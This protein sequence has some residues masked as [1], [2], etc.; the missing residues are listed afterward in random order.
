[1]QNYMTVQ[2]VGANT[3][4]DYAIVQEALRFFT[5]GEFKA[6]KDSISTDDKLNARFN[7]LVTA[8]KYKIGT[9]AAAV[10][11]ADLIKLHGFETNLHGAIDVVEKALQ[12]AAKAVGAARIEEIELYQKFPNQTARV[13]R[14]VAPLWRK[15]EQE[16]VTVEKQLV[17]MNELERDISF[18]ISK[19]IS[20]LH[21]PMLANQ[22]DPI[23]LRL[24]H[25]DRE[26][27]TM[28]RPLR[29]LMQRLMNHIQAR[30][31]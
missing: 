2:Q 12:A 13:T 9:G 20:E 15:A 18:E 31:F 7:G 3:A 28:V 11:K 26:M 8:H 14:T 16:A 17:R 24:Q 19:L 23:L 4:Q 6:W 30:Y 10:E 27:T 21:D 1:M 5:E 22:M 25:A 29:E